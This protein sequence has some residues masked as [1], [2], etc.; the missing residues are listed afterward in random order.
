[1]NLPVLESLGKI[2]VRITGWEDT[3]FV[4]I[5]HILPTTVCL[6]DSLIALG[7]M[8]EKIY[9]LGKNY[10][11]HSPSRKQIIKLG[12]HLQNNSVQYKLGQFSQ[13]FSND[14]SKLWNRVYVDQVKNDVKAIIILDDGGHCLVSAPPKILKRFSIIGIEQTRSGLLNPGISNLQFPL[15]EV[16]SSA[17]KKWLEPPIISKAIMTKLI[18]VSG[19]GNKKASCGV[20]GFGFI[21]KAIAYELS[22]LGHKVIVYD[23]NYNQRVKDHNYPWSKSLSELISMSDYI[24]GCTGKDVSENLRLNTVTGGNK[25]LISCSSDDREFLSLLKLIQRCH[26]EKYCSPFD[27]LIYK[28]RRTIFRIYRGGFPIN[29]DKSSEIEPSQ[30]IQL[31]RGLMLAGVLQ[32]LCILSLGRKNSY[33][34]LAL[35]TMLQYF[36]TQKWS[37]YQYADHRVNCIL[38]YFRNLEWID[39]NSGGRQAD[40]QILTNAIQLSK[41]K[42]QVRPSISSS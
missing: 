25:H 34:R 33:T 39:R 27:D 28:N 22:S 42:D 32:A 15:I 36:V 14:I 20:A 10:S 12:I 21:G 6:F 18:D 40:N 24:F 4:G 13:C 2:G 30:S 35:D 38:N 7:A 26:P 16:A 5:Q 3:V 17:T 8:P 23:T 37:Q 1:L 41:V 9:L 19:I 29:F 31:T 11:T